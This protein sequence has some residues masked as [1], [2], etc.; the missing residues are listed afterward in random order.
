MTWTSAI[1][2]AAWLVRCDDDVPADVV[3]VRC[4]AANTIK[5]QWDEI[6]RLQAI[7]A[8]LPKTADG[9]PV[10]PGVDAVFWAGGDKRNCLVPLQASNCHYVLGPEGY[11]RHSI[12]KHHSDEKVSIR[13]CYSTREAAEAAKEGGASR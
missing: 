3:E 4:D 5:R 11:V 1:K 9:V 6:E 7:V 10:V 2:H 12:K 8:K 13:K